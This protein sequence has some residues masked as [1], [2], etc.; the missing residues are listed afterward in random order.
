LWSESGSKTFLHLQGSGLALASL[1]R[2]AG[3]GGEE[4]AVDVGEDTTSRD[5]HITKKLVELLVV[6]DGQLDV[7]GDDATTLVVT[8]GVAG[9]LENLST[10]VLEDRGEVDGGTSSDTSGVAT[11]T[12][13]AVDTSDGELK[14]GA[15][16]SALG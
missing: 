9:E 16:R 5:G 12:E 1:A 6:S 14:S 15:D 7:A 13:V 11:V 10:K 8:R 4:N 3:L 2:L